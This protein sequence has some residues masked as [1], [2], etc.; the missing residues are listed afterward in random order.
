MPLQTK[1]R[2][3][4]ALIDLDALAFNFQSSKQFIGSDLKYMAVVKADAY[5]HGAPECALRLEAD[6]VDW[7]GVAIPEE[8]VELRQ[9]GVTRP[10]LC[11]GSFW[12][13]QEALIVEH[14]LTPVIF[15]EHIADLLNK[16]AVGVGVDIDIH[17]K[18]DTGMGR[19][20]VRYERAAEFAATL[21]RFENLHVNGLMTHFASA[22]DPAENEFTGKQIERFNAALDQF[23]IAAHSPE[24]IDLANSPG[25]IRHH[26]SRGNLIRLGGALYGLLDDILIP[27]TESPQLKPVLSLRSEIAHIKQIAAGESL[28]YGRTF[29]T[30][31]DSLIALVP[32]GYADGYPRNDSD[33]GRVCVKGQA[34][35]VV[36]RISMDWTLIDV[37]DIENA[38]VGDEVLLIGRSNG[39]YITAADIAREIDTIGYEITCGISPRVPRIFKEKQ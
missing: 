13:G 24:W 27:E 21:K 7:F 35:P 16:Y 20:G 14:H 12:P 1:K 11:L 31:R 19:V 8:G 6:G 4:E 39:C 23:L 25:A 9:A 38:A 28:G 17:V 10:I 3:T 34:A 33:R 30:K 26:D 37:T 22:E 15:D 5:G 2:P 32:V 18:I 29:F 36:G